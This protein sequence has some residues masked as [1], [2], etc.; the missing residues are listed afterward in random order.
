MG[1][2]KEGMKWRAKVCVDGRIVGS[3][4]GF[5]TKTAAKKWHDEKRVKYNPDDFEKIDINF[6]ELVAE[7]ERLH[8][9]NLTIGTSTRYRIDF[10]YRILPFFKFM[11]IS[12]IKP[13]LIEEFKSTLIKDLS[14]KSA[15][16]CLGTLSCLFAKAVKWGMMQQS[17]FR[18]D[19]FPI[20]HQ[21]YTWWSNEA[22][23]KVF[24]H[25]A[26]ANEYYPAFV[27]ALQTGMRLG[28][29]VGLSK[30]DID[31]EQR[32]IRVH[33]QWQDKFKCYAPPKG[34]KPRT[35]KVSRD[36]LELI[37][38]FLCKH[39]HT[40]ILFTTKKGNRLRGDS[41]AR[42]CFKRIIKKSGVPNIKFHDLRHTFASWYMK[43]GGN[44]WELKQILGHG[45]IKMTE[46]YAH[47]SPSTTGGDVV[48][49]TELVSPINCPSIAPV[50]GVARLKLCS[51]R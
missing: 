30:G 3:K 20:P 35:I 29:I 32:Q 27:L 6:E 14:P 8:F 31:I 2:F 17:P 48:N 7:F 15:N 45:T 4:R 19:N 40:E 22:D 43:N 9:P 37:K 38:P 21:E 34:K 44:I 23:I 13:K 26:K 46:K 49:F 39:P 1:V 50:R 28:E 42:D 33:R 41:L 36:L 5:T 18:V 12:K 25:F 24:L 47:H 10:K 16:N 11:K 51:N